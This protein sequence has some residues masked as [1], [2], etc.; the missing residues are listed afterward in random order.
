MTFKIS[1]RRG[2]CQYSCLLTNLNYKI[3][4]M[5]VK[6]SNTRL[7]MEGIRSEGTWSLQWDW[8]WG[9]ATGCSA[10]RDGS[11]GRSL[12]SGTGNNTGWSSRS[13]SKKKSVSWKEVLY[14]VG[15]PITLL[16]LFQPLLIKIFNNVYIIYEFLC[17]KQGLKFLN[18]LFFNNHYFWKPIFMPKHYRR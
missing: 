12:G 3:L 18:V 14:T 5:R 2:T 4:K 16:L 10:R 11:Q 13:L 8:G 9:K 1:T 15:I 7:S 6:L 17:I